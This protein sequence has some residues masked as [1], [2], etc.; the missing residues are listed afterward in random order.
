[1]RTLIC[2][3]NKNV[4]SIKGAYMYKPGR[5][6][7]GPSTLGGQVGAQPALRR[8]PGVPPR[9]L[10]GPA[11]R[12]TAWRAFF[13]NYKVPLSFTKSGFSHSIQNDSGSRVP[14]S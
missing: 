4:I 1:M 5:S 9:Q 7:A 11:V 8:V 13:Q 2:Y 3:L 10:Q 14:I 6:G 12:T